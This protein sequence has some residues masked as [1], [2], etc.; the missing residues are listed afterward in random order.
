MDAHPWS[1]QIYPLSEAELK[2]WFSRPVFS[3]LSSMYLVGIRKTRSLHFYQFC[4]LIHYCLQMGCKLLFK[5]RNSYLEHCMVFQTEG[6]ALPSF[7]LPKQKSLR[8]MEITWISTWPQLWS[9]YLVTD[10]N[11]DNI[12]EK[13]NLGIRQVINAVLVLYSFQSLRENCTVVFRW[14]VTPVGHCV[15]KGIFRVGA[16]GGQCFGSDTVSDHLCAPVSSS[17]TSLVPQKIWWLSAVRLS[18]KCIIIG[19]GGTNS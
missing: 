6:A 4:V 11:T 18:I 16:T 7:L 19:T 8:N 9:L 12:F 2:S 10:L 13:R 15:G 3:C 17:E 5:E 1:S 14:P